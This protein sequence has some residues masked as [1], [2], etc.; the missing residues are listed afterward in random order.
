MQSV[1]VHTPEN[2]TLILY[3]AAPPA[4]YRLFTAYQYC[5]YDSGLVARSSDLYFPLA[6]LPAVLMACQASRVG[7]IKMFIC[8]E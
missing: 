1:P 8:S 6:C 4:A 7:H 5:L 3:F 2:V